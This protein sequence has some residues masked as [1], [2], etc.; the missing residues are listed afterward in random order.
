MDQTCL[1]EVLQEEPSFDH[2]HFQDVKAEEGGSQDEPKPKGELSSMH[3]AASV[4]PRLMELAPARR[5]A[6]RVCPE[7][8][9][10]LSIS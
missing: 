9:A 7:L 1:L 8:V 10:V 4:A 2:Q 3:K 6:H 5:C